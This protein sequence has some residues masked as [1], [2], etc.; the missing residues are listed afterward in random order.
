MHFLKEKFVLRRVIQGC[1]ESVS[2]AYD[3]PEDVAA[4]LDSVEKSVLQIRNETE[5]EKGI[6][7]MRVH[8]LNVIQTIQ[9]LYNGEGSAGGL[10]TGF[11][12]LDEMTN[13][14]HG[15]EMIVV[16]ARPS[17]GKTSFVMNIVENIS[18][19]KENPIPVAVFSLEMSSESLVQRVLCSRAKVQMQKLRGGFLSKQDLAQ[20]DGS[21]RPT[22]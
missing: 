2:G 1:T 14:L 11:H 21:S 7:E 6:E 16:A 9:D 8:V 3:G 4:F 13:G 17:M 18:I 12:D 5:Q 22:R 15:G 20:A 19:R 10:M